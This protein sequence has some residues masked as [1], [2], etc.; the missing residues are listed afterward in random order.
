MQGR[1][2]PPEV[3]VVFNQ[4]CTLALFARVWF[5]GV[6]WV[7]RISVISACISV[8]FWEIESYVQPLSYDTKNVWWGALLRNPFLEC[9]QFAPSITRSILIVS[10]WFS[11]RWNVL[12][13]LFRMIC[14]TSCLVLLLEIVLRSPRPTTCAAPLITS[15]LPPTIMIYLKHRHTD[16]YCFS[17]FQVFSKGR[18][19]YPPVCPRRETGITSRTSKC[20]QNNCSYCMDILNDRETF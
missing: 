9:C 3:I 15:L 6:T 12:S 16:K 14:D 7:I 2:I 5:W 4:S 10:L 19:H 20:R 11:M 18:Y 8:V 1:I 17:A 13:V